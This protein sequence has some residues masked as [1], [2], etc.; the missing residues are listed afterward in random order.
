LS[1][2]IMKEMAY[3]DSQVKQPVSWSFVFRQV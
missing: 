1:L 2:F 3:L